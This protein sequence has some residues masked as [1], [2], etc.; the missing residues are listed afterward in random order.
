MITLENKVLWGISG[1]SMWSRTDADRI[2]CQ[3][4][5]FY[6]SHTT[7][8]AIKTKEIGQAKI[9]IKKYRYSDP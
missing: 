4:P 5:Q 8:R 1:S 3:L 2:A 9:I 6:S 7:V